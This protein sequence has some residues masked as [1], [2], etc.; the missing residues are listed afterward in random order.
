MC[1]CSHVWVHMYVH[2][3]EGPRL[4]SGIFLNCLYIT[5]Y[6]QINFF[7]EWRAL[8]HFSQLGQ[9]ACSRGPLSPEEWD[10]L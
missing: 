4:K 7:N 3:C 1:V 5:L 2:A 6:T 9:P 10:C 8:H